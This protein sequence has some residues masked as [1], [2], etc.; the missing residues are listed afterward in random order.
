LIHDLQIG[1]D[2]RERSELRPIN[3]GGVLESLRAERSNTAALEHVVEGQGALTER[4]AAL[5]LRNIYVL[6][7]GEQAGLHIAEPVDQTQ[8]ELS[9]LTAFDPVSAPVIH[10][11]ALRLHR[12]GP[13]EGREEAARPGEGEPAIS[14]W[15]DVDAQQRE[16]LA[17]GILRFHRRQRSISFG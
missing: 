5:V 7:A 6:H 1:L 4:T 11:F 8:I 14:G 16:F 17:P 12:M 3:R 2:K 15:A 10:V 9:F 13:T